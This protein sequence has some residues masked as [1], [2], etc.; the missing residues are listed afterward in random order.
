MGTPV[1]I[2]LL[3]SQAQS[4]QIALASITYTLTLTWDDEP[5][6]GW[7]MDIGDENNAPI[8]QGVPLVT[9]ADL[10]AQYT[11][12][13]FPGTL[14]VQTDHDVNAVPTFDNLGVNSHLYFTPNDG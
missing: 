10:L 7:M 12:L 5:Q 6:G 4:F 8:L 2:P 11:Y 14:I 1:E 3:P 13:G 9:G